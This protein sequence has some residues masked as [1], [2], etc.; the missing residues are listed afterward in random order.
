MFIEDGRTE[1]RQS[2]IRQTE[3]RGQNSEDSD[4]KTVFRRRTKDNR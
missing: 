1:Y 2:E 4:Q 3:N